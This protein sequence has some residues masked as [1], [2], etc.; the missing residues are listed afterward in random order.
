MS[1]GEIIEVLELDLDNL[2]D[3]QKPEQ[4]YEGAINRIQEKFR[5]DVGIHVELESNFT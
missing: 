5:L 3:K 1:F 4:T 2:I